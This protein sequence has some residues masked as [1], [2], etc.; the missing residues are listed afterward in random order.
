MC[1]NIVIWICYQINC[2]LW[3]DLAPAY[4]EAVDVNFVSR[5]FAL[6]WLLYQTIITSLMYYKRLNWRFIVWLL[7]LLAVAFSSLDMKNI[8]TLANELHDLSV[9]FNK[10]SLICGWLYHDPLDYYY[11][12]YNVNPWLF[13]V[14]Y[15]PSGNRLFIYYSDSISNL[16]KH[17]VF[18]FCACHSRS[19]LRR[20]QCSYTHYNI[21]CIIAATQFCAF[22][23]WYM[24]LC[25]FLFIFSAIG[26][27]YIRMLLKYFHKYSK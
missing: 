9:I 10:L 24:K 27:L 21:L 26:S 19:P 5:K 11:D 13:L 17:G 7:S 25:F 2:L 14:L 6:I 1:V 3:C 20:L 23:S 12:Y 15:Y 16:F 4:Y 8:A 18:D 22:M